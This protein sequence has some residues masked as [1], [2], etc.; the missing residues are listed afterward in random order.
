MAVYSYIVGFHWLSPQWQ[1]TAVF[2]S[3]LFRSLLLD[4]SGCLVKDDFHLL[5]DI[6]LHAYALSYGPADMLKNAHAR[7]MHS[8]KYLCLKASLHACQHTSFI[9]VRLFYISM[10]V[11]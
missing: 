2:S 8:R 1:D 9:P 5:A 6:N 7:S 11:G 4:F 10:H 3:D